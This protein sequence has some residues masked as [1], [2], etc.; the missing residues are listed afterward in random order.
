MRLIYNKINYYKY[1]IAKAEIV[2]TSINM[3]CNPV[4]LLLVHNVRL[5]FAM[6][7]GHLP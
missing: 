1:L 5:F 3:N 2:L 6:S 4:N 7:L